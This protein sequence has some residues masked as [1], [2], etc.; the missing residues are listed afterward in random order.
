MNRL[1]LTLAAG[2][3]AIG[4]ALD[5]PAQHV[6]PLPQPPAP[7]WIEVQGAETPVTLERVEVDVASVG[8][9]AR[10]SLLLTL[11]N[12]NARILEGMLQF[13]LQPGQHVT[14]FAL[15]IDG[16]MRDAVPV[17]KQQGRQVFES[18][19]RRNVDPALLEQTAG[20]HFRLRVYPLPARGT[21]QVR[22]VL[23]EAM[24]RDGDHWRLGLPAGLLS[25]ASAVSW[26]DSRH[27]VAR[28]TSR[29]RMV[30]VAST[31]SIV[32]PGRIVRTVM[33]EGAAGM[34]PRISYV[35]RD[36]CRSGRGS[37]DSMTCASRPATGAMCCSWAFQAPCVCR[38][39]M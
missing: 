34:R 21:R 11:R 29:P 7:G 38:V 19:E 20:N 4:I 28:T 12:P 39:G 15:D 24:R 22:L 18:I 37:W 14:A 25:A 32:R 3:A 26:R 35:T 6:R 13:P 9:Q 36:S 17:P 30:M 33:A 16:V 23:D 10:T 27:P 1:L 31:S 2:V 8:S 5:S